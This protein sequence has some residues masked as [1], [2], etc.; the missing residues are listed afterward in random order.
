[1][2][3]VTDRLLNVRDHPNMFVVV[4]SFFVLLVGIYGVLWW[5]VRAARSLPADK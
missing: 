1:L 5:L 2:F 4:A 3:D